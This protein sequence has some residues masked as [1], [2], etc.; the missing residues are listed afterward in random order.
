MENPWGLDAG[1]Q[2]R[3]IDDI[4]AEY[5]KHPPTKATPEDYSCPWCGG[6]GTEKVV[7]AHERKCEENPSNRKPMTPDAFHKAYKAYVA[8]NIRK[9]RA[10]KWESPHK[11][12][13]K[14]KKNAFS[15]KVKTSTGHAVTTVASGKGTS[16]S[17]ASPDKKR[18]PISVTSD[19]PLKKILAPLRKTKKKRRR[20]TQKNPQEGSGSKRRR[21]R[22]KT[23]N[24]RKSRRKKE[25][26]VV[27]IAEELDAS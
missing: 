1:N 19:M 9:A 3:N 2:S 6:T 7:R 17:A 22:R 23:R 20:K 13:N 12:S 8:E 4:I 11:S 21:R 27:N 10:S 26:G 16:F 5:N 18:S 14:P 15:T 25:E 24:R